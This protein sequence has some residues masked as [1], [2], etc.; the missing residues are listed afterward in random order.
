MYDVRSNPLS[1][2]PIPTAFGLLAGLLL[3][4]LSSPA[5]AE[6]EN[7][8]AIESGAESDS[9]LIGGFVDLEWR[10][11]WIGGHSSHGPGF[12]AGVTFWD[13]FLRVGLAG[14][15]RPGPMNPATFDVQ[16]GAGQEYKGQSQLSLRSDGAF[17][18]GHLGLAFEI[19]HAEWLSIAIPVTLGF[20]GFGFYLTGSDRETPDGAR[21]SEW[22]DKLFADK[23]SYLGFVVDVGLRLG[24]EVPGATWLRPYVGVYYTAVPGFETVVRNGYDG[25]SM[26]LGI[27]LGHG[28]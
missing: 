1:I 7:D 18:G 4:L 5:A 9:V 28:L 2:R 26:S 12:A 16:L 13:G 17:M 8:V 27:E 10:A 11:M 23:D 15:G 22:E 21:V 6:T 20:G 24:V 19:P 14:V 25:F 3:G